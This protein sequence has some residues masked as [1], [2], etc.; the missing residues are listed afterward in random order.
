M[1]LLKNEK[2]EKYH[3]IEVEY[4]FL[5][6]KWKVKYRKVNGD[7]YKFEAPNNYYT[8]GLIEYCDI[9]GLFNVRI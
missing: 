8:I 5:W 7:I 1:K 6:I 9:D 4:S 3:E 2:T